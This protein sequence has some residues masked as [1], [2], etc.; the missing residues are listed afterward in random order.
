MAER[1]LLMKI[2]GDGYLS[3]FPVQVPGTYGHSQLKCPACFSSVVAHNLWRHSAK[4]E[5]PAP[6]MGAR[7]SHSLASPVVHLKLVATLLGALLKTLLANI[8]ILLEKMRFRHFSLHF[9]SM[10]I[11][12]VCNG[13]DKVSMEGVYRAAKKFTSMVR[14]TDC[15]FF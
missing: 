13:I 6:G 3:A 14:S 9:L 1:D 10:C 11:F 4:K 15:K 2:P 5:P 8:A 7:P 12:D